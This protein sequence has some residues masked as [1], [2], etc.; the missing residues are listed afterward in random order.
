MIRKTHAKEVLV[1]LIGSLFLTSVFT[2][3]P[4]INS[5]YDAVQNI[6]QNLEFNISNIIID[7]NI[8]SNEWDNAEQKIAW[9][10]DADPAN[11]DGYNYMYLAEDSDNLYIAVDLCSDQT[12]STTEEWIGIWLNTNETDTTAPSVSERRDNWYNG[13]NAGLE[14]LIFD[15]ENN[16]T[17]PFLREDDALIGMA[18]DYTNLDDFTVHLGSMDGEA[19]ALNNF[20]DSDYLNIT[21]EYNGTHYVYRLDYNATFRDF[22]EY[23]PEIFGS[24]T[25]RLDLNLGSFFNITVDEHFM[26]ILDQNGNL[27]SDIEVQLNT[28]TTNDGDAYLHSKAN[29]TAD[30]YTIVSFNAIH[31]APFN[32]SLSFL[33]TYFQRNYTSN[34]AVGT[35][36]Y[37]Y[38]SIKNYEVEY[39]FGTTENNNTDHRVYEF[40]IPKSELENYTADTE[41]GVLIGGYGTL[42]GWPNTHNWVYAAT[43]QTGI[44]EQRTAEYLYYNMTMKGMVLPDAPTIQDISPDPT[45]DLEISI[46]W[47]DD[48]NA[49]SWNVY[50]YI[51]EITEANLGSATEIAT[52]ITDSN[53]TDT[54]SGLGTYW[55]A[56]VANNL[57][58]SSPVSN[59]E[60]VSVI[61]GTAP[62]I[63][64]PSDFAYGYGEDGY[65]INWTCSD[66]YPESYTIQKNGTQVA[67]GE[68]DGSDISYTLVD[69]DPNVYNFTLILEDA[70]GNLISDTVIVTVNQLSTTETSTT[71]T[72]ETTTTPPNPS[73]DPML[74]VAGVGVGAAVF[75]L[76]IVYFL[77]KK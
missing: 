2:I 68:W 28:G 22:Y 7:G 38:S 73:L 46:D 61:D 74:L 14:S 35:I 3:R 30:N 75:L 26:T 21:S 52:E 13:L 20:D 41:L 25:Q 1:I 29:Y 42:A 9:Y 44:P 54:V 76:G 16:R 6:E 67:T 23:F 77:R 71:T 33:K 57:L 60:S 27:R 19:S 5:E 65:V 55:Y 31:S 58:G 69:L 59:S 32:V 66:D 18:N 37:P 47:N 62:Q 50:R 8:T 64:G 34:L 10:M 63:T 15:T 40:K 56:V 70:G 24:H 11:S 45:E 39:T 43:E 48:E 36:E 51:E 12:G 17:Y 49:D 53:Y 4:C 72:S